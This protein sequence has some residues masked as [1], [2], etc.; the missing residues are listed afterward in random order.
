MNSILP[1]MCEL[2]KSKGLDPKK[3]V[4]VTSLD[5]VRANKFVAEAV[6]CDPAEVEVPVIGGHAGTAL[7]P[8]ISKSHAK[9]KDLSEDQVKAVEAHLQEASAEIVSAK[10]GKGSATLSMAYAGARLAKAIL[11]GLAGKKTT[12]CAYVMCPEQLDGT[13]VAYFTTKVTFGKGGVEKVHSIK[14]LGLNAYETKRLAEAE[15]ALKAD[16][17]AGLAYA[18]NVSSK[19][20]SN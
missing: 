11:A 4:G 8:V 19:T 3:I 16:I 14:E 17:D 12:E 1:A 7:L 15:N 10:D 13:S 18:K 6:D 20:N 9:A 2:Y 5:V